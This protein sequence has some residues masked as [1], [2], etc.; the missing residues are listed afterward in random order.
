MSG[1]EAYIAEYEGKIRSALKDDP[2]E[3]ILNDFV[4]YLIVNGKSISTTYMYVLHAKRLLHKSSDV[5][6]L[7]LADYVNFISDYQSST[8]SYRINVYTALKWFSKFL[9]ANQINTDNPMQFVSRPE[10]KESLKTIKRRE[11]KAISKKQMI[12]LVN[13]SECDIRDEAICTLLTRTGMRSRA[14]WKLDVDNIDF[15]NKKI[16]TTDKGDKI[17]EYYLDDY[18]IEVLKKWLDE[19]EATLI[20]L[21]NREETAL[22]ISDQNG[23]KRLSKR[24]ISN[25]VE[26]YGNEI[27]MHVT[28]HMLRS[29]A[30]TAVYNATKDIY[31]AQQFAGHNS[32]KTTELYI[33]D[34]DNNARKEGA[35]IM[36]DIFSNN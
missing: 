31:V 30:I 26:K 7:K 21:L 11:S 34:K 19:R 29:G 5:N 32:A 9:F 24:S 13:K 35:K 17:Q 36:S 15:D 14:L 1:N 8:A 25:I 12:K 28:P 27:G 6:N 23:G 10:M 4:K 18:T 3:K 16:I 22:F 20:L 33:R 2:Q